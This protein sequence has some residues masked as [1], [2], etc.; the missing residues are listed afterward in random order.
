[1]LVCECVRE[2]RRGGLYN[3]IHYQITETYFTHNYVERESMLERVRERRRGIMDIL[4]R[5]HGNIIEYI[6]YTKPWRESVCGREKERERERERE[7]E[8]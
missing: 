7:Q 4:L 8:I 6:I 5:G 3:R 1:M 2:R